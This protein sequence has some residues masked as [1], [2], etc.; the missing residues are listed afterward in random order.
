LDVD[1]VGTS[2]KLRRLLMAFPK[3]SRMLAFAPLHGSSVEYRFNRVW[4]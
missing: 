3:P 4:A 2:R 1:A